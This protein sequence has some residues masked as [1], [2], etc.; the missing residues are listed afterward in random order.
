[1]A[2]FVAP[3]ALNANRSALLSYMSLLIALET[4]TGITVVVMVVPQTVKAFGLLALLEAILG[5]MPLFATTEAL[6]KSAL[7]ILGI[8]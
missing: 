4:S 8:Y 7:L 6:H 1:M 3:A 2:H 5:Y